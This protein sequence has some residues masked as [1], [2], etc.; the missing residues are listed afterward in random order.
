LNAFKFL[1]QR[2][3]ETMSFTMHSLF[4]VVQSCCSCSTVAAC[5]AIRCRRPEFTDRSNTAVRVYQ[6]VLEPSFTCRRGQGSLNDSMTSTPASAEC[7]CLLLLLRP[8]SDA[9]RRWQVASVN[10]DQK[11]YLPARRVGLATGVCLSMSVCVKPDTSPQV[12]YEVTC[13]WSL[14]K[15]ITGRR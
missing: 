2:Y 11:S 10:S 13:Q 8:P 9:V 12:M 3:P 5:F 14:A 1:G 4:V 7:I 6:R 15:L